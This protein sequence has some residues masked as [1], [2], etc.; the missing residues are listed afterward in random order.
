MFT[1]FI[2][3][4]LIILNGYLSSGMIFSSDPI[5][6]P[7]DPTSLTVFGVMVTN[8]STSPAIVRLIFGFFLSFV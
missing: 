7:T 3:L 1:P 2:A 8:F 5:C 6:F 4:T